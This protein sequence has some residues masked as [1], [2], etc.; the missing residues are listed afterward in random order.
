M[1]SEGLKMIHLI[2]DMTIN[3]ESLRKLA[4]TAHTSN[5]LGIR[6]EYFNNMTGLG[7]LLHFNEIQHSGL[8]FE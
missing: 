5:I 3:N 8:D 7:H 1:A 6:D 4:L 2:K